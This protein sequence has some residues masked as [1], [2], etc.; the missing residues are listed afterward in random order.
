MNVN[1][2]ATPAGAPGA[3]S[4]EPR[5]PS[6]ALQRHRAWQSAMEQAQLATWFKPGPP[7]QDSGPAGATF[8]ASVPA[9]DGHALQVL[10]DDAPP[11]EFGQ[12]PVAPDSAAGE[13]QRPVQSTA[14]APEAG[15]T[16]EP[17]DRAPADRPAVTSPEPS[18]APDAKSSRG[19][20]MVAAADRTPLVALAPLAGPALR[21]LPIAP[22]GVAK[23][24]D[25]G[26]AV[27]PLPAAAPALAFGTAPPAA[28]LRPLA[29]QLASLLDVPDVEAT[30]STRAAAGAA[31]ISRRIEAAGAPTRLHVE[32][33][34]E[35]AR[36]W[37][38]VDQDQLQRVP[39][40]AGQVQQW[41]AA[42]GVKL[43]ALVCNGRSLY[44]SHDGAPGT[45]PRNA[46]A[47]DGR[48][49]APSPTFLP[50]EPAGDRE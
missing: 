4:P 22:T 27:G 3:A 46:A 44:E 43:L 26:P 29:Q 47:A 20:E 12:G 38:G 18:P 24:P 31:A 42:S 9:G 1:L 49:P 23:A 50:I 19:Q 32:W 11:R 45:S 13:M 5:E 41:L 39:A 25:A 15:H 2:L 10:R 40:L 34:R 14:Q 37:I 28:A 21:S 35:G 17:E 36:L 48:R 33:T 8:F 30:Q 16:S 7:V 6:D